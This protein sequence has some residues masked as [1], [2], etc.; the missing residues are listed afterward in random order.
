MTKMR[1]ALLGSAL[2]L[3]TASTGF[4]QN[5]D[6]GLYIRGDVGGA[7]GANT[8]FANTGGTAPFILGSWPNS[9]GSSVLFGGGIGY[10]INP[11][12]RTDFTLDY[13]HR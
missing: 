7:F 11:M 6:S 3:A 5:K 13:T 10:R 8:T 2:L 9:I 12:F 1:G 4:A